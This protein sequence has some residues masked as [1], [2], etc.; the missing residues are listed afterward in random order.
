[1]ADIVQDASSVGG[2]A[3]GAIVLVNVFTPRPGQTDAFIAAQTAEYLRLKGKVDG[4][5]GNRLYRAL[6][7]S[8]A[9]NVAHFASLA[10]YRAWRD[11]AL[12]A[13]HLEIIRPLVA[14]SA[15]GLYQEVYQGA[16]DA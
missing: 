1:M 8:G 15:P 12:F 10:Q 2:E 9:V 16:P 6:D 13:E 14:T 11:S 3:E 5:L 7:G 4:W